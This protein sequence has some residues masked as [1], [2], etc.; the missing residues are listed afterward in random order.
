MATRQVYWNIEGHNW[1]YLFFIIA[2]AIFG[3]GVYKRLQ[4]WKLGQPENRWKDIWPGIKDVLVYTFAHKRILKDG[5]PGL[6]HAGIFYGFLFLAFATAVITV[7]ADFSLNIFHGWLYLFIKVTANLFGLAALIAILIAAYRRYI[8]R[9]D[10][11]DNKA[12]DAITLALLFAILLTGFVIQGARMAVVPDPWAAYAFVGQWMAVPLKALLNEAQLLSLHVFLWWLHLVLAMAFIAYFS[13]SKLFHILLGPLNQFFR[14]RGPIGIPE[15][16]D[17]EDENLETFGKSQLREFSWKTLFNTDACLRCGRCQD[18]CPAYL[19]GKHLSPKRII[20]D[21]R[22]LM[23]ETGAALQVEA[24]G[25]AQA[26]G[27][28]AAAASEA[29]ETEEWTGRALIGEVI[30][31]DDLWA[32]T[33]CR[34]CEQQCPVFVEHV[35]KTIDMRR[36]LVLME[37]RFPSEAQLAFRNME[38]NGNPWGIGWSTRADFLTG[39]GVKTFEEAPDAEYLYWPGCSGAFDARNQKVSAALVKL[40][41]AAGVNFAILGNEEK[42]CGDS[43]RKLGNEYLFY[44]LATEN[45]EVMNG[46]GVKKI[47]TQCPHCYNFLKNEYPQFGGNFEVIHHTVFLLDLVKSGKLKLSNSDG[48]SVTYHDSCYLGRYN[49]IYEQPRELLKA[50]GL[51]LKEMSH[52]GEKSFCCGAGGGRMWLEEHEGQRINEMRTD[53]AIAVKPDYVGTACPFCLTMFA[54]GIAAREA[55]EQMKALDVA[56]ILEKAL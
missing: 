31:E 28:E 54:D 33:T 20:Q 46:Y 22:V 12:D 32:C 13:Y 37:T 51:S 55:G 7:Q 30:P 17:F 8:Q 48:K 19:S 18:N 41:Q 3:Y 26:A 53:Q 23:E 43:A 47:I 35:D 36:N 42:C 44:S 6:M 11:L 52:T 24:K 1:L 34:S 25:L 27:Q 15:L 16:I 56:E 14:N 49:E 45:I 40:L 5:Y 10:R 21:M 38:N 4:L 9:P 50:V 2:L 29:E 39:L